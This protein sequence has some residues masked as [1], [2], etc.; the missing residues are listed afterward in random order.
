MINLM[1]RGIE[2]RITWV[3]GSTV[4]LVHPPLITRQR[5]WTLTASPRLLAVLKEDKSPQIDADIPAA[6]AAAAAQADDVG[7][8]PL[9]DGNLLAVRLNSG[10]GPTLKLV[11]RANV[12]GLMNRPPVPTHDGVY[13]SGVGTGVT[14]VDRQTGEL[15]WRTDA[16]HDTLLAVNREHV[17]VRDRNGRVHVYD[18]LRAS[19]L[20]TRLAFPLVSVS[21]SEFNIPV[22]NNQT[23]RILL[24]ADNGLLVCLRDASPGYAR[25]YVVAP[26][27]HAVEAL[28]PKPA[29][30][31]PGTIP[32][33]ANL[34]QPEKKDAEKKD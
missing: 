13:L 9:T 33:D 28:P 24:A 27:R 20:A 21:L 34:K 4:R 23:D 8:V 17:Y 2:P 14:R 11:W 25:Q 26:P 31:A 32:A 1:P 29:E 15:T 16:T 18:R 19:D 12:G 5:V 6:P 10:V 7:Y 22:T 3:F 30:A